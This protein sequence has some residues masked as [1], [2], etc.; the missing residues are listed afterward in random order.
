MVRL[1][2]GVVGVAARATLPVG[3]TTALTADPP[4]QP[5][6]DFKD[7][8][9]KEVTCLMGQRPAAWAPALAC[10]HLLPIA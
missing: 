9:C 5:V 4:S 6:M 10:I 3:G 2:V 1:D 7:N 8:S